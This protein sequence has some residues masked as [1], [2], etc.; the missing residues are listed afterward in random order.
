MQ[1]SI[2]FLSLRV[3][4]LENSFKVGCGFKVTGSVRRIGSGTQ[5]FRSVKIRCPYVP[6]FGQSVLFLVFFFFERCHLPVLRWIEISKC[7]LQRSWLFLIN[8]REDWVPSVPGAG[9]ASRDQPRQDPLHPSPLR[10]LP[11][12]SSHRWYVIDGPVFFLQSFS[13]HIARVG[14]IEIDPVKWIQNF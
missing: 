9:P 10:P 7:R 4:S 13:F 3:W 8:H 1:T 11:G 5:V 6:I 14:S 12:R 2:V